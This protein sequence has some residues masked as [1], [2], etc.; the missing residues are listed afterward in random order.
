MVVN[1]DYLTKYDAAELTCLSTH[2]LKK[3]RLNGK[4]IK[5]IHYVKLNSRT[6]RYHRPSLQTWMNNGYRLL[7]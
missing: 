5:G 7:T 4:L 3:Y 2:T 1:S 6:I